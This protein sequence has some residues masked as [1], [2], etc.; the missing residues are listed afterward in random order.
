MQ[1]KFT[2]SSISKLSRNAFMILILFLLG[3]TIH[4]QTYVNG[5]LSTG[6]TSKS[7]VAAPAGYTWSEVQNNAGVTTVSNTVSGFT[8][9]ISS[10]LSVADDFT[11]P[12]GPNWDITKFTF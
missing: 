6:A 12:A 7:G 1:S 9:S 11:V 8:T 2:L 5:N 4:A 10:E 3:T